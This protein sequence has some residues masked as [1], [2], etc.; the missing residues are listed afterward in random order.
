[1]D[2]GVKRQQAAGAKDGGLSGNGRI[3]LEFAP[4]PCQCFENQLSLPVKTLERV[5][6]ILRLDEG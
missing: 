5:G 6:G 1:M 3:P 2:I 4:Q